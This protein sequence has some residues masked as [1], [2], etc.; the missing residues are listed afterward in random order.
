MTWVVLFFGIFLKIVGFM[1]LCLL[2]WVVLEI[3][4]WL[5]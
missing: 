1:L 5:F 4:D 2:L 3:V